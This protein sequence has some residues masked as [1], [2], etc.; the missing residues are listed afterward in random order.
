MLSG[1]AC[2]IMGSARRQFMRPAGPIVPVLIF[3]AALTA[4]KRSQDPADSGTMGAGGMGGAGGLGSG[5]PAGTGGGAAGAGGS[6]GGSNSGVGGAAGIAGAADCVDLSLAPT[7]RYDFRVVGSGFDAYDGE[8]VR[9]VVAANSNHPGYGVGE[10][11][12]RNGSF[13]IALPKTNEPY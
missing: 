2:W 12:I 9:A 6:N 4:C 13:E 7:G 11:T 10:T 1:P 5:G 3:L 8:T